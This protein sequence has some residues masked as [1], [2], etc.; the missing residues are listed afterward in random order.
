MKGGRVQGADSLEVWMGRAGAP[1]DSA[2]PG[3]RESALLYRVLQTD[4]R[5]ATTAAT[6]VRGH[7][8]P[9]QTLLLA[10]GSPQTQ[11]CPPQETDRRPMPK[12]RSTGDRPRG[13]YEEEGRMPA[14]APAPQNPTAI[15]WN[16]TCLKKRRNSDLSC[17]SSV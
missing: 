17:Y 10:P 8:A 4:R 7:H 9:V 16:R 6:G 13:S 2:G 5:E 11:R 14:P 3:L 1:A 15:I 12:A